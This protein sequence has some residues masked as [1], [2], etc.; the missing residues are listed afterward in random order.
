MHSFSFLLSCKSKNQPNGE[1][2]L[3]IA[4]VRLFVR[5]VIVLAAFSVAEPATEIFYGGNDVGFFFFL[6]RRSF[7]R[8]EVQ[9][10]SVTFL[11]CF[12]F[13]PFPVGWP[14]PV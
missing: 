4:L 2:I 11:F 1:S 8:N 13:H 10:P 5:D 9:C 3:L 12:F 14:F 6:F 7:D